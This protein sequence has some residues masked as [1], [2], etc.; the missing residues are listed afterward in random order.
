MPVL[1]LV[2]YP[3]CGEL[4]KSWQAMRLY[5]EEETYL[6]PLMAIGAQMPP[7]GAIVTTS[8]ERIFVVREGS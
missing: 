7:A 8:Q 4:L 1:L 3:E 6:K 2:P 5:V